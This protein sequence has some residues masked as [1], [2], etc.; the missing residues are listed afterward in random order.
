MVGFDDEMKKIVQE[1]VDINNAN[2]SV[3]SI[4]GMGGLEKTTLTKS[5]YNNIEVKRSFRMFAWVIISQQ[6]NI[7]EI[8]KGISSE[9]SATSS[10]DTIRD[11]SV[12][13]SKKLKKGKYLVVLDDVWNSDVWNE[14]LKVFPDVNNGSKVII[15][16]RFLNVAKIAD[17]TTK[18][19]ELRCLDEKESRELFLRNVFPRQ[20]IETCCPT[21]LGEYAHQLVQRCGGLPLALVVLG[22]L[23]ST[24]PQTKDAWRK[25]VKSMKGQFVEGGDRCLDILALSYND[26]P[27]FLKSCFLYFG[28]FREDMNIPAETLIRLWSA[29]GFLPPKNS[30]TIEEIGFDCLKELAQRYLIQVTEQEYD[31]SRAMM[32]RIHDLLHDL[33]I[34]K[35]KETRFLEIYQNDTV[36]YETM[37]NAAQQLIIFNGIETLNY[38]NPKLRGLLYWHGKSLRALK[39]QLGRF[40]Y[41]TVLSFIGSDI[42]E[43]PS[44]IKSLDKLRYLE[45]HAWPLKEVPSWIGDLYNLQTFIISSR[46][47]EKVSDSLWTIGNLR[48]VDLSISPLPIAREADP[49]NMGNNVPKNLQTLKGVK[50]GSWIGNT[51]PKLTNLCELGIVRVYTDHAYA[52]SSSLQ[53]LDRL[54][55]FSIENGYEIPLDNIITAFSNQHCLKKLFLSVVLNRRQLPHID[56]FPQHL[57]EVFLR[58]FGLEQDPMETLEKLQC[59]RYLRLENDSYKGKQMICSATGFPQLFSLTIGALYTLEEWKIEEKAMPCLKYLHIAYGPKLKVLPEGLKSVPL[60]QL[61]LTHMSREFMTRIKEKTGE[62]WYKIQHVPEISIIKVSSFVLA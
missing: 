52:L 1:L 28:C 25:V 49:P 22:R 15:T 8:L 7:L 35:A 26:F 4:V 21:D 42:S 32:C 27:Y 23:V 10:A 6:Y 9:V 55:S 5:V 13:I 59:L 39:G 58:F 11:L 40:K 62:D 45:L 30:T 53:K 60:H 18:P 34:S 24:K 36:D 43:F 20:D 37:S 17:P 14:L 48:Y 41:L 56:V 54:A 2:R 51:L 50:A 31:D 3:I 19:H 57:V 61:K 33:C 29:E 12:A 16:T 46:M 38:S 47:L 44:E